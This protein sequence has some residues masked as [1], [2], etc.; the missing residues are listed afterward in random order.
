[1]TTAAIAPRPAPTLQPG[2]TLLLEGGPSSRM[3]PASSWATAMVLALTVVGLPFVWLAPVIAKQT[4]GWHRWWLTDRRLVVRTGFIGWQIRSV[5]LDRIV[6]VTTKAS[7]W[8]GVWG[9][10]HV[11]VRDMTGEVGSNGVS[12][13]LSLV[14]VEDAREVAERILTET[15][16][17]PVSPSTGVGHADL[18]DVVRLLEQLVAQTA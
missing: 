11:T 14:G 9:V 13:G 4:L 15:P 2:E 12:T 3:L 17:S 1:M 5:P 18:G 7:W 10:E 6:D 16:S 8:D